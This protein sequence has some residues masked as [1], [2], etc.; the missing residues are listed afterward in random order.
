[1]SVGVTDCAVIDAFVAN[2]NNPFLV[3]FPRTGSA[4]LRMMIELAFDR[5][6]LTRVYFLQ[7]Q[8]DY[9]FMHTHDS[10]LSLRRRNVIYLYRD[11]VDT[12]YSQLSF[13]G[14]DVT[15]ECAIERCSELYGRHLWKWLVVE[16]FT[17]KHISIEMNRIAAHLILP[18]NSERAA[19]AA[20][21]ANKDTMRRNTTFDP[22]LIRVDTDYEVCRERFKM[23][24]SELVWRRILDNRK[25]I[26]KWFP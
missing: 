14:G 15:D 24:F 25:E 10:D 20:V 19:A 5:P 26:E 12:V 7:D 23:N 4:W 3:S 17:E 9:V 1:M 6:T 11:P 16:D 13:E 2:Q 18:V 22:K 21:I 8:T